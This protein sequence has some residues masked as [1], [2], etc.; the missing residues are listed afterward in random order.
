MS[1][2]GLFLCCPEVFSDKIAAWT[3]FLV[4][5]IAPPTGNF[6]TVPYV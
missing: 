6:G 1:F 4:R 2:I 5:P 3:S